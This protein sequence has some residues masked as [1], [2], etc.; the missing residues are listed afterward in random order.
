MGIQVPA[1]QN[2]SDEHRW[3]RDAVKE[4]IA[5]GLKIMPLPYNVA[6]ILMDSLAEFHL[7]T[8]GGSGELHE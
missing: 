5:M 2:W 4:L 8:G 3:A 7:E 1:L 6:Q